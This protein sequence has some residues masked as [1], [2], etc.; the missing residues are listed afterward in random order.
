MKLSLKK[1]AGA[2]DLPIW[3]LERWIRQGR[4]PVQRNGNDVVFTNGALQK[5][6]V[7]HN[8]PF[9]LDSAKPVAQLP[10]PMDSLVSAIQRGS[11]YCGIRGAD[12]ESVLQAATREIDFLQPAIREELLGKLIERERLA[13]T[14]IGNGIAIPHPRE[15]LSQPPEHAVI[16]VCFLETPV[17]FN[18]IDDALVSVLFLLISPTVKD[19]LHLLSRLSYCIRNTAFVTFLKTRPDAAALVSRIAAFEAQLDDT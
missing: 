13:S 5:W 3:T 7:T 19:H 9:A 11:V 17:D 16:A 1:L 4:I 14:G 18:A 10:A 12:V 6:A 8:L 15:P 2:L